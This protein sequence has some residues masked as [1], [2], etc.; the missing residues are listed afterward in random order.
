LLQKA[1]NKAGA[2][3]L[4]EKALGSSNI[5]IRQAAATEL[6]NLI[7]EGLE[8]GKAL[9]RVRREAAGSWGAAF[10]ALG[11]SPDKEK[12][13]D[14]LL[15][16]GSME[17]GMSFPGEAAL[18]TLRECKNQEEVFFNEIE[19]AAIEGRFAAG[20]SRFRAALGFFRIVLEA[21]GA[22]PGIFFTY[23]AL[24]NDLGRS[25]QYADSGN[26]GI[27]LFLKWENAAPT[28][29]L[30]F[31]LFFFAA[32]IARQRGNTEM[33][34]SLFEQAL[35]FAP[36]YVQ[37]DACIWYI[38]DSSLGGSL[39]IF[40]R[41]LEQ[42][43]TQW[44][45]SNYF[46][47]VLDKLSRELLLKR[48]WK[49]IIRVFS[50]IQNQSAG[51]STARYAWIVGRAIEEGYLSA[52]EIQLAAQAIRADDLPSA[53]RRI[54]YDASFYYRSLSAD[55][56]SLDFPQ[57]TAYVTRD[58]AAME[59][60]LGFFNNNAAE[61][62]PRHISSMEKTLALHELRI[63]AR[64]LADAGLYVESM[65][66]VTVYSKLD[67]YIAE[68]R[69]MEIQYPRPFRELVEKYAAETGIAPSL[70]YGLIRT[71]SAFQSDVV[72]RAGAVGLTQLMP[73][74]AVEMAGRIRRAGGPDYLQGEPGSLSLNNPDQN[75][76]IGAYYLR[77][78]KG[79]FDNTLLSLMA[80][81]GGMNRIRRWR[82]ASNLP[83]DLFLDT[84]EFRE[85]RE[86]G[87]R[88]L[89]AAWIYR[90]LYYPDD[91]F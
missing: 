85:T 75:I 63:L 67:G 23:P 16:S 29:E 40:I 73:E 81:N 50:I 71:E 18:Y 1:D 25:F 86:Y 68:Q 30:R 17:Y 7:Y 9:E 35:P 69:D 39:D 87:R 66:L 76:H 89:A 60:L 13:L 22:Q 46:D 74:T 8:L 80:Y 12:V 19:N 37:A 90:E 11:K 70:L 59:F 52:E 36:D 48:D 83:A 78:L 5:F 49:N 27:E 3:E 57:P 79:R 61:F 34:I 31:R 65:R 10:G 20:Q 53:F 4:F 44:R 28:G 6:C 38:L 62:A 55:R 64:A 82:A 51:A 15:S 91:V 58:S 14:F 77:Y 24:V 45:D 26:E 43:I 32:R 2:A 42:Y 54:A 33:G 21:S 56:I 88:V 72:S 47:D 41:R 84:V